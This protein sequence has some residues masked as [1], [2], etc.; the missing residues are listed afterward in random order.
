ML[1]T[2]SNTVTIQAYRFLL[3]HAGA[4]LL[5]LTIQWKFFPPILLKET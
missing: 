2:V 1:G 3:M 4:V 5:S